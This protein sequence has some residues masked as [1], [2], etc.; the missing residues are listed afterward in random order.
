MKFVTEGNENKKNLIV[1]LLLI[2]SQC[3]EA[4]E[5]IYVLLLDRELLPMCFA[6]PTPNVLPREVLPIFVLPRATP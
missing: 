2:E 5:N 1:S 3:I 6:E 4:K